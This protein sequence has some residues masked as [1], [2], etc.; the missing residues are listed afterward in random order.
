MRVVIE[1][2]ENALTVASVEDQMVGRKIGDGGRRA[3]VRYAKLEPGVASSDVAGKRRGAGVSRRHLALGRL[4]PV[5]A[6]TIAWLR[7]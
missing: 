1:R 5:G 2:L 7:R 4:A 3:V 6:S